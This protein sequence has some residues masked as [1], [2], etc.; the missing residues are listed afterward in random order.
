[1]EF[2]VKPLP[3]SKDALAPHMSAETFEYHY[4]KH[5]KTYMAKLKAAIE[6]TGEAAKSL[7]DVVRGASGGTFNNAAQVW[8]HSFFWDGMKP[9]GGGAP[10]GGK[11]K[12]I[13]DQLGGFAAFK[14]AWNQVGMGQFGSGW[15]W[16]VLDS[17]APKIISTANADTPLTTG[18]TPLLVCDVWEHAY[19]VDYRNARNSFLDAFCDHLINWDFVAANAV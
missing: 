10:T 8:N 3:Y 15:V 9:G 2:E 17:G 7:E 13:L 6:G 1:M 11:A 18:A 19:Y 16:L 4:E 14:A 12:D 5:H